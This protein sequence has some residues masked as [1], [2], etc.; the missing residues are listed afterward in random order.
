MKV[1]TRSRRE[2][3]AYLGKAIVLSVTASA[4][5]L[6]SN[7]ASQAR[8]NTDTDVLSSHE[9]ELLGN[10]VDVIV[11]ATDTAGAKAAGVDVYILEM[12]RTWYRPDEV[13]EF[14]E[15]LGALDD[16]V[17]IR[18][19]QGFI[20]I[21]SES[22]TRAL[23]EALSGSDASVAQFVSWVRQMTLTGYYTSQMGASVE[24]RYVPVPA[25][26]N[27]CLLLGPDDRAWST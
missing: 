21:D 8:I 27:P 2:V 25:S 9:M 12:L 22:Q 20:D 6:G 26:Y 24:L 16:S 4:C 7:S 17:T 13:A 11:P 18:F 14:R 10:I 23:A 1:K 15:G 5:D 3:L 19:G